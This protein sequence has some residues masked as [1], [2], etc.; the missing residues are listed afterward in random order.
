MRLPCGVIAFIVILAVGI[1][2]SQVATGLPPFGS[3]GGGPFD[4]INLGNLNVN[5]VVPVFNKA[6]RGTPFSYSL[7]YDSSIWNPATSNGITSWVPQSDWGWTVNSPA[8]G[9]SISTTTKPNWPCSYLNE[10]GQL[11]R[12][13]VTA[14]IISTFTDPLGTPHPVNTAEDPCLLGNVF[15]STAKDGSG[16]TVFYQ[17]SIWAQSRGGT[18][19]YIEPPGPNNPLVT[20]ID[21]NGN[22]FTENSSGQ[23]FDTLSS[24][25]PA[26]TKGGGGTP[27][28]PTTLTYTAPSG[29]NATYTI[30]YLQYTVATHFAVTGI[31]EYGPL[32]RALVNSIALPDGTSYSFAYEA[33]PGTCTP[34]SGTYLNNC[35]TARLSSVTLPTGGIITY[36]YS[37]GS[38]GVESDGSTA[39]L[40]RTLTPGGQW[41]YARTQVSGTHWQTKITSPPDPVNA[42]SASDITLIDF[43]QDSSTSTPSTNFY[44]T[45]RQVNQGASTL[46]TTILRC[47]NT[48]YASCTTA[49]VA[50]PVTQMDVYTSLPNGNTRA[51]EITYNGYGLIQTDTEYN[52]GVTTGAA[53]SSTYRIGRIGVDYN[54]FNNGIVDRVADIGVED[55]GSGTEL[56]LLYS[57][58]GYDETAITTTSGTPQHVYPLPGSYPYGARGNLTTSSTSIT[59]WEGGT[60]RSQTYTYYDT[61]VTARK[62]VTSGPAKQWEG[63]Y[64]VHLKPLKITRESFE[65]TAEGVETRAQAR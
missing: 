34:L 55:W 63:K 50:S 44:E 39:G 21:K 20:Y 22:E 31:N 9:G 12:Y 26:L 16:W 25:T 29:G 47:Y 49:A 59:G 33:T 38:N 51:S 23:L 46:L 24:T 27:A 40:T 14:T 37:G 54:T 6:D 52:Y 43:Q 4:T 18:T 15:Q 28:S 5:F 30:N 2:S 57:Q 56:E 42:G 17:G 10:Q 19:V 8:L 32:S 58:Y 64:N 3:F 61:G 53:P 13:T 1:S 35:V 36:A 7:S 48:I 62:A 41:Q 60:L 65:V 11:V 45:Q